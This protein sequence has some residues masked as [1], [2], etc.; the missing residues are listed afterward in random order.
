[1][2]STT[3]RLPVTV[4][5]GFLGLRCAMVTL[6]SVLV[7]V[8][9]VGILHRVAHAYGTHSEVAVEGATEAASGQDLMAGLQR[10][11]GDHSHGLDCQLFDQSCPD[12]LHTPAWGLVP[13]LPA[14]SWLAA[15]LHE[16]FALFERFYAAR[17]PPAV[18][19]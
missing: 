10:L 15:T 6:L 3:S 8:Q 19:H 11:W 12:A 4:L 7:L 17:G 1:M 18:L 16:R 5:S 13:V 9:T 14:H 2:K